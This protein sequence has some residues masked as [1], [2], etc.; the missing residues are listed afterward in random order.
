MK[1][2]IVFCAALLVGAAPALALDEGVPD[3]A[4]HPAVG[5]MGVD[6]DG[7]GPGAPT[8]YCTGFVASDRTFVTAGHC[9]VG[10]PP[11]TEF[12]LTLTPGTPAAPVM[13]PALYPDEFPFS[14]TAPVIRAKAGVLHPRWG[15]DGVLQHDVAVLLMD[16]GTFAGVT[17]I[18]LP[19]VD[20]A[21]RGP[22]RLVG[23]G[24]DPE[25]GDEAPQYLVEGYRQTRLSRI[26]RV[27]DQ[28]VVMPPAI[29]FGDSGG[30]QLVGNVAISIVS[31]SGDSCELARGQRLDTREELKFL[32]RYL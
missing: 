27:T 24:A 18:G 10:L 12:V 7:P 21:R 15:E 26:V 11:E 1:L 19:H 13:T 8:P 23:Y 9:L 29:C 5:L 3:R 17:P 25:R 31:E 28:Q 32:R 6:F 22:V 2:F 16:P 20:S 4:A 30:P 14:F